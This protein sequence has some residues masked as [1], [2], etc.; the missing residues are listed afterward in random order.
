[1]I[2]STEILHPWG[3]LMRKVSW[4]VA[5]ACL[6]AV[7]PW[8]GSYAAAERGA[9]FT[10][11]DLLSLRRVSD[12][13]V[14]P[15]DHY[16]VFTLATPDLA[17]NG[18]GSRLWLLDLQRGAGQ[19]RLLTAA[20]AHEWNPR[21]SPDGQ[22][23][24]FLSDRSGSSQT[25]R[26]NLANSTTTQV[27]H[28]QVDVET[29]K[30]S[31][32]G[33]RL[34]VTLQVFPECA[35]LACTA[36]R[37]S[38]AA[39]SSGAGRIYDRL[40]I[41]HWD[42]WVDGRQSHLFSVA[43]AAGASETV[44]TPVDLTR[45]LDADVPSKPFGSDLEFNFSPDGK[46]V[47][48]TARIKGHT[49][50]WST[51][52]DVF[53]V[54]V[55]GSAAPH[56]L[57]ADNLAWDTDPT[58]S[59]DGRLL[60]W[61]ARDRPQ[62]E[63]DRFHF[64]VKDRRSGAVWSILPGWDRSVDQFAF[65]RDGRS[66]FATT[67]HL[68]QHALWRI[69]LPHG[70][71]KDAARASLVQSKGQVTEFAPTAHS[72]VFAL[73]ALDSPA[74]LYRTDGR[75][76]AIQ[77]LTQLNADVLGAR[78]LSAF[79]QFTFNGW[80]DEP[81]YGYV[82]QPLGFTPG[83]KHPVAFIVHGGPQLSYANGW[84]YRWNPQVYA[85]AGYAVVLIDFHGSTGYGQAFTDSIRDDWGGKPLVDLQK[86][87]AAALDKYPWLDGGR[88]CALGASYSG[89]MMNWIE[90]N[91]PGAFR[92]LV[93][94]AGPFDTRTMYYQTDEM[95][96]DEYEFGGP[97]FAN[98]AGFEKHNPLLHVASWRTPMLVGHGLQDFNVPYGQGVAAFTALQRLGIPSRLIVF[99]EEGHFIIKPRDSLL[100]HHETIAWLDRWLQGDRSSSQH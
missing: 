43:L 17:S 34:L 88:V 75:G 13:Q 65:A 18:S 7:V 72:V 63:A 84:T 99:P 26:L 69:D 47:A 31:P 95:W 66:I 12:L 5:L 56:D 85:A 62:N 15:D 45:T 78:Q 90:G 50:A 97:Q 76:G 28:L 57:T 89:Q 11:E 68:G 74:D 37:L 49:E 10:V 77:R 36:Q 48:F 83:H 55:D 59:P 54:P 92:C 73:A 6:S 29:L 40:F 38:A 79:E 20:G 23:L 32:T 39:S 71:A 14:A 86:G 30:V 3:V 93:N 35:D 42:T 96:L 80:N 51:N 24:Y 21:W 2:L 61:K 53:E 91:W 41:R 1:M 94:Y 64:V 46:Q 98:P 60:V 70:G 100:W 27:T 25:W 44:G 22:A 67:D 82:V 87:L 58:Y 52:F 81:V 19:P 8:G 9:A 33:D 4:F 16:V